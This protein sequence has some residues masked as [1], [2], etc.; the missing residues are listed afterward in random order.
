MRTALLLILAS[1]VPSGLLCDSGRPAGK[2]QTLFGGKDVSQWRGFRRTRF[3]AHIWS[4]EGGAL[5][6]KKASNDLRQDLAT[7]R[8]FSDF[9]LEFEWKISAGGNSG[10]K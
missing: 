1:L 10:V 5:K 6:R 2:W 8:T 9:E 7:R 4:V 3:P